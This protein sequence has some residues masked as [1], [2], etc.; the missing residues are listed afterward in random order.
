MGQAKWDRKMM[1]CRSEMPGQTVRAGLQ[2]RTAK[3]GRDK[4]SRTRLQGQDFKDKT[5]RPR[6][7]GQDFKDKTSGTEQPEQILQ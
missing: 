4:T 3:T 5:S 6:L 1:A 2:C 7:Q